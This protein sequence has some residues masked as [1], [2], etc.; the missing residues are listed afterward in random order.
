MKSLSIILGV[1]LGNPK[2]ILSD[3]LLKNCKFSY[4]VYFMFI[5]EV[6]YTK[7]MPNKTAP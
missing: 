5:Q 2:A 7:I 6:V 3:F 4:N 1:L